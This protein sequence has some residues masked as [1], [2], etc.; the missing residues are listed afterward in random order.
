VR[1]VGQDQAEVGEN[2]R[3][4]CQ[5][6]CG[7]LIQAPTLRKLEDGQQQGQDVHSLHDAHE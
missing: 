6:A 2:Q 4:E 3:G 7:W 5:G 1:A